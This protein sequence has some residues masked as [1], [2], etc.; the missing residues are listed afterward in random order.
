MF[1]TRFSLPTAPQ[2]L[3]RPVGP[4]RAPVPVCRTHLHPLCLQNYEELADAS[5]RQMFKDWLEVPRPK[6]S[7]AMYL[8]HAMFR[9]RLQYLPGTSYLLHW[10]Q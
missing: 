2:R 5:T 7:S 10:T 4:R 6:A 9:L 8:S 3:T 1:S